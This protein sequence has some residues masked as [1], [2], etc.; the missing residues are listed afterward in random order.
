MQMIEICIWEETAYHMIFVGLLILVSIKLYINCLHKK[1]NSFIFKIYSKVVITWS[2]L[3]EMKIYPI[4]LGCWQCYKFFINF[5]LRL[6]L[7]SFLSEMKNLIKTSAWKNPSNCISID[8]SYF[9]CIF[10]IRKTSI[11]DQKVNKW[12]TFKLMEIYRFL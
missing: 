2:R 10:E 6:H 9:C 3:I 7:K 12:R 8:R 11:C 4:L 5:I 1:G